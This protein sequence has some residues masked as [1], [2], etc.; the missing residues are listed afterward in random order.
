MFSTTF[1]SLGTLALLKLALPFN[2][3]LVLIASIINIFSTPFK[4]KKKPNIN[5]KTVLLTGGKMTKA[6]QL[7]RSFYSAGHRVILVETHKYWLSGHRFSVAVDKF[8]TIPDPVK[9]KE[10]YIDGLL[11]IVKRENVDIFIPVSSPV[12]SYYDSVAKMVLS[13]YCKVLHFDVEM[14]LVLDDKASLCQKASSLG[15]TSPASYLITDVQEILDFDFSK[16][17]HKYILKSIKYDSVYRLNMTQFPFE[18]MEEYV[19]SLPISEENPWVMQQFITGQEYCTH[20]TVLNGKIRLHCCSMSSHFQVN[21][22]HVDNQKIYEW[23]EEFV[24]KL[25]LTGQISFDFIQTDDGTVYPIECNPRTHSAISMFYNH[26]LVADAYLNDGDDAPITPLESSKPTFWTY[27]ELWR[28]TEVRSPQDLSQWW[29]K[30]TKGQDGIFSWQDPLPFLMVH[31][32]QIPLLLFG[33]LIKLK[34]W[35]KIDFNIGKLV[36]SAG[37]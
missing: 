4:I 21:Y 36:E 17:N 26:P 25:N 20:S 10:G 7:A 3:T 22:E 35:V 2:L 27:H 18:G 13:P 16:N 23:V 9:D 32:W 8:F 37:D 33:N 1:K 14:T 28:L 24:G 11:D 5:S 6:L 29:Q 31:H 12:A 30:V 19:R 15:L 34:P